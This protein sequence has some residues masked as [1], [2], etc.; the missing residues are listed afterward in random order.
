MQETLAELQEQEEN[1]LEVHSDLIRNGNKWMSQYE[2]LFEQ[3]VKSV[4]YDR[5]EYVKRLELV[6]GTNMQTLQNLQS[7]LEQFKEA[8]AKEEKMHKSR[9]IPTGGRGAKQ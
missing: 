5:D 3:T 1:L 4:D 6:I 7:K 8:M 9:Q 2:K